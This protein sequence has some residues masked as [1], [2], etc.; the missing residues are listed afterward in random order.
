MATAKESSFTVYEFTTEEYGSAVTYTDLQLKHL[1]NQLAH[2]SEQKIAISAETFENP[3]MFV[4]AH[5][6]HRGLVDA[7][8]FI[9]ELHNAYNS[10]IR[11]SMEQAAARQERDSYFSEVPEWKIDREEGE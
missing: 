4:R 5:E 3:E 6:Y 1:Q 9:V 11:E 10:E 2:Y 7:M 8:R